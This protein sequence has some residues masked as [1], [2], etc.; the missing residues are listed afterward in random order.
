MGTSLFGTEVLGWGA[1]IPH[2]AAK[3][4]LLIFNL[5]IMGVV[6]AQF[7]SPPLLPVSRIQKTNALLPPS[8]EKKAQYRDRVP[9]RQKFEFW[10]CYLIH[11]KSG[12]IT[13]PDNLCSDHLSQTCYSSLVL[14]AIP[15]SN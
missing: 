11:S 5:H 3:I 2:S 14:A 1:G 7:T 9:K 13:D 15:V 6:S 4:F 8:E 10:I 12:Q